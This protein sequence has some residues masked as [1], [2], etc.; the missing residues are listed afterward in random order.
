V[1]LGI[2]VKSLSVP[3]PEELFLEGVA[4]QGEE[5]L[6]SP[7][8]VVGRYRVQDNGD[9]GLDV[10]ETGGLGVESGDVVGVE[11]KGMGSLWCGLWCLMNDQRRADVETLCIGEKEIVSTF[12]IIDFGV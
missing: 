7:A 11:S 5:D 1:E 10:V 12:P 9:E 2:M 6:P 8:R 3:I 4:P